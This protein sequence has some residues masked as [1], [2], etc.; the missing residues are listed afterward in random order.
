M[1]E[2]STV[3][4]LTFPKLQWEKINMLNFILPPD[5]FFLI[6]LLILLLTY[7]TLLCA[8]Y[9]IQLS[10]EILELQ[11]QLQLEQSRNFSNA[12]QKG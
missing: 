12:R 5:W 1:Y 11:L 3:P 7:L 4:F 9:Y 10:R 8:N 6:P 2:N